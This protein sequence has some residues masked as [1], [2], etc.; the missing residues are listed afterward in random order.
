MTNRP[1]SIEGGL[2][3]NGSET[4]YNQLKNNVLISMQTAN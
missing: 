4:K 1:Q 2:G 3:L